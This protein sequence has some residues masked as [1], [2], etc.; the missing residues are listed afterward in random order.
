MEQDELEKLGSY[1]LLN[2][3]TQL[4]LN[5]TLKNDILVRLDRIELFI[6]SLDHATKIARDERLDS[7][8]LRDM[9][10]TLGL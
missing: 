4:E 8:D 6:D 3:K 1:L 2:I 10:E 5:K 7:L 9:A